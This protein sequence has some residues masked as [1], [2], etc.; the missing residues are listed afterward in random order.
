MSRMIWMAVLVALVAR[1]GVLLII[2]DP[3]L[4]ESVGPNWGWGYE[5]ASVGQALARGD[6]FSDAFGRGTG[7][8]AW[9]APVY[10]MVLAALSKLFGGVGE[11]MAWALAALQILAS[12]LTCIALAVLAYGLGRKDLSVLVAWVWALYPTSTW[13]AVTLVWDTTLVALGVVAWLAALTVQGRG[14]PPARAF[15]L[16]CWLGALALI[17]PAPLAFAPALVPWLR[18]R[19][20]PILALVGGTALVLSPWVLRNW[21]SVGAPLL[22]TN[23]GV[24]L[25]VGNNE[26]AEGL[27][28]ADLHPGYAQE[29]ADRFDAIG[30]VAYAAQARERA[31]AWI[32]AHPSRF[33]ELCGARLK[34]FWIG[35]G[36]LEEPLDWMGWVEWIVGLVTGVGALIGIITWRGGE[37]SGWIVRGVLLLFPLVYTF[38]HVLPRYRFPI[39]GVIVLVSTAVALQAWERFYRRSA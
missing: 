26:Q 22:R 31:L 21:I 28:I 32:G 5:Q 38:T 18:C 24:E 34:R 2:D 35:Q 7:A 4:I 13:F 12:S 11:P 37:G 16:G 33:A 3:L 19:L 29:E 20:R 17:N 9:V 8:T 27:W 6:G 14:I 10:P 25:M 39:E 15:R 1:V 23:L 36:P 30:E